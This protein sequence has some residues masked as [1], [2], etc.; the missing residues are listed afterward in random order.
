MEKT[1]TTTAVPVDR[2]AQLAIEIE[3]IRAY[4]RKH[5]RG[6]GKAPRGR[7][8][9]TRRVLNEPQASVV[10]VRPMLIWQ[11]WGGYEDPDSLWMEAPVPNGQVDWACLLG[12]TVCV[13]VEC[14]NLGVNLRDV[15]AVTQAC[16]YAFSV[17]APYAVL[18]DGA[19]WGIYDVFK[20]AL[21]VDKLI[22]KIDIMKCSVAEA[23][24]FFALLSRDNFEKGIKRIAKEAAPARKSRSRRRGKRVSLKSPEHRRHLSAVETTLG[25]P[26][27][28]VGN[29][30]NTY[31]QPDGGRVRFSLSSSK[32]GP[33]MFNISVEHLDEGLIYLADATRGYGWLVPASK[34]REFLIGTEGQTAAG[35]KSSWTPRVIASGS[36]DVLRTSGA[37]SNVF[38]LDAY[39]HHAVGR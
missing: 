24:E 7:S 4:V 2:L 22:R 28:L 1:E 30:R 23:A 5:A 26:L 19:V 17:A 8:K 36:G 12:D 39:R 34:L 14:K 16:A 32:R 38:D 35:S 31:V 10:M 33:A 9:S 25:V 11:K 13:T 20:K 29:S 3:A 15:K 6:K 27:A 21:P 18:T 37:A